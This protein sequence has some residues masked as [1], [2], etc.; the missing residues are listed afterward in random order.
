MKRSIAIVTGL[1]VAAVL[2][3]LLIDQPWQSQLSAERAALALRA[4]L[5]TSDRFTCS[6]TTGLSTP[7]E[8]D[9]TY[10]CL[11]KTH[12]QSSGYFVQT[13]GNTIVAVQ[14]SG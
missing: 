2:A 3:F 1:A 7:G 14:P 6:G 12:P 8:P 4:R 13:N 11:N 5:H 9:W 10:A